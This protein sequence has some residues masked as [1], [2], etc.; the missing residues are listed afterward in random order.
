MIVFSFAQHQ[1]MNAVLDVGNDACFT[2]CTALHLDVDRETRI[3]TSEKSYSDKFVRR[4][5]QNKQKNPCGVP[6]SRRSSMFCSPI[7]DFAQNCIRQ[8]AAACNRAVRSQI[9]VNRS[10]SVW[11]K[12]PP[13]EVHLKNKRH[14]AEK[15]Q[16]IY[17]QYKIMQT[18]STNL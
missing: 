3:A 6:S 13:A 7:G 9:A 16:Q 8:P 10:H 1:P 17:D 12:F 18:T 4:S 2:F 11:A 5:T 14:P 15:E